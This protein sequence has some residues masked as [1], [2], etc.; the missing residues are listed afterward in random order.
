MI[1]IVR[2]WSLQNLIFFLT[3]LSISIFHSSKLVLMES[4]RALLYDEFIIGDMGYFC[5]CPSNKLFDGVVELLSIWWSL[6]SW[7]ISDIR[8]SKFNLG[9]KTNL[10]SLNEQKLDSFHL[11]SGLIEPKPSCK[12]DAWGKNNPSAWN[13]LLWFFGAEPPLP[14]IK[15]SPCMNKF[16]CDDG[17]LKLFD[18]IFTGFELCSNPENNKC[19]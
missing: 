18:G 11:K 1:R 6:L 3:F 19:D 9:L 10:L 16:W 13:E 17:L 7:F 5:K 14:G 4:S 2:C 8:E 15:F 12:C